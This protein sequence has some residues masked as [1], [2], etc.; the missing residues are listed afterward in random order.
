MIDM[1][2]KKY[3]SY[4][5]IDAELQILKV[6]K[7]LHYYKLKQSIESTQRQL[8]PENLLSNATESVKSYLQDSLG[9]IIQNLIPWV[10]GWFLN[11]KKR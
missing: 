2:K 3:T 4:Q 9:T 10:L 1:N 6:Q 5:E 7:E 11:K 8:T